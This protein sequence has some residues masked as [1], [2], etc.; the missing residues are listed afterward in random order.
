MKLNNLLFFIIV[1]GCFNL[2]AQVQEPFVPRYT[3]SLKGDVTMIANNVLSRDDNNPYNGNNGN[4]DYSNNEYVDIDNDG[5]TFNSSSADFLNP[6]PNVNCI[7]IYR[8]FL[9]WAA[10]DKEKDNGD[11]NQPNWN[12]DDV[13][14]MLPGEA[15]YTTYTADDVIYRGRDTHFSN[16]PVLIYLLKT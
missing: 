1:F 7:T 9:Y 4:H 10:A 14:L 2:N 15:N 16:E 5:S 3:E 13:K 6:N 11:D 12:F 8:A